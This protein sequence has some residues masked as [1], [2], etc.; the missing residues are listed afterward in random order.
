MLNFPFTVHCN[1][2]SAISASNWPCFIPHSHSLQHVTSVV[3]RTSVRFQRSAKCNF[4]LHL[5]SLLSSFIPFSYFYKFFF[6]LR[7]SIWTERLQCMVVV[8]EIQERK[9]EHHDD[10]FPVL[11]FPHLLQAWVLEC[12]E[13]GK[14]FVFSVCDREC[15]FKILTNIG[16][17]SCLAH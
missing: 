8:W 3:V 2:K 13:K 17:S 6:D 10:P 11:L 1:A 4:S 14:V 5:I 16:M 7:H 9:A 15:A 12:Y